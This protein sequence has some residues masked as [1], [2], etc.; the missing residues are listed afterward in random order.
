MYGSASTKFVDSRSHGSESTKKK[1]SQPTLSVPSQHWSIRMFPANICQFPANIHQFPANICQFP[2]N[3]HQFPAN[4]CQFSANIHQF[5]AS[6]CQFSVNIH[7]FP[8]N[9]CQVRSS[10][11]GSPGYGLTDPRLYTSTKLNIANYWFY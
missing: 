5:P 10:L 3:I 7:Q 9:I 1:V 4:I 11:P 8:A 2:A 6:I